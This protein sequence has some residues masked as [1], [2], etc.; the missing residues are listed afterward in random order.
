LMI[1]H[2]QCRLHY[3]RLTLKWSNEVMTWNVKVR[4]SEYEVLDYALWNLTQD[5]QALL[6]FKVECQWAKSCQNANETGN[7]NFG[8]FAGDDSWIYGRCIM[9]TSVYSWGSISTYPW[10]RIYRLLFYSHKSVRINDFSIHLRLEICQ[11]KMENVWALYA[12]TTLE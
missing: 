1:V 8:R 12:S 10:A 3:L 11:H 7:A 9:H 4:L 2:Q 5:V 6:P